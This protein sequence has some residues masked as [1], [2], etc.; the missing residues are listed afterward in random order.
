MSKLLRPNLPP[1][2]AQARVLLHLYTAGPKLPYELYPIV[3]P[4]GRFN[5]D[6]DHGSSKG[7][8]SRTEF[9]V[10]CFLGRMNARGWVFRYGYLDKLAPADKRGKWL[11]TP[12]GELLVET[13]LTRAIALG[14][15][16]GPDKKQKRTTP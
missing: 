6:T 14:V 16:P 2:Q 15:V 10:N 11:L 1:S 12:A 4:T 13:E 7:G 8:P 5:T 9:A 3:S